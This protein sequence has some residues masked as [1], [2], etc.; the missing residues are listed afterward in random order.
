MTTVVAQCLLH[1][2]TPKLAAPA[3][4]ASTSLSF[5]DLHRSPLLPGSPFPIRFSHPMPNPSRRSSPPS[6]VAADLL[7]PRAP[8]AA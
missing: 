6:R 1:L 5:P 3:R 7:L 4:L 2:S 8:P